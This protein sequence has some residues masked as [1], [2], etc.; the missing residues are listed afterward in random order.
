MKKFALY[1]FIHKGKEREEQ[2]G[3]TRDKNEEGM[4][5]AEKQVCQLKPV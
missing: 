2:G 4:I 5:N 1:Y 3:A